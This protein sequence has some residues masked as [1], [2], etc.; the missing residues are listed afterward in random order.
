MNEVEEE[1]GRGGTEK[2]KSEDISALTEA[3][4]T[5]FRDTRSL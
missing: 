1:V 3:W 4:S 2:K 5:G